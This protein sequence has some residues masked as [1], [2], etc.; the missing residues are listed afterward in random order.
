MSSRFWV[1][2]EELQH[3]WNYEESRNI[4]NLEKLSL[5]KTYNSYSKTILLIALQKRENW[6]LLRSLLCIQSS[7]IDSSR[8]IF[9]S[10]RSTFESAADILVRDKGL[11]H[12]YSAHL[13]AETVD[14]DFEKFVISIVPCSYLPYFDYFNDDEAAVL[15]IK[16]CCRINVDI[17]VAIALTR[18]WNQG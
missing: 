10:T 9:G 8:T 6:F 13:I 7:V 14:V 2:S 3:I 1:P 17:A 18:F 16:Q 4:L 5:L 11:V 15:L 12:P